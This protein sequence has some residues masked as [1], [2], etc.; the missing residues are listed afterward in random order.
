MSDES[1]HGIPATNLV[2]VK[3]LHLRSLEPFLSDDPVLVSFL[4]LQATLD[5]DKRSTKAA[6]NL[7]T[8]VGYLNHR[9]SSPPRYSLTSLTTRLLTPRECSPVSRSDGLLVMR[10]LLSVVG[11]RAEDTDH[12]RISAV[13]AF[14]MIMDAT[15]ESLPW[16]Q[17]QVTVSVTDGDMVGIGLRRI[18]KAIRFVHKCLRVDFI[19][20]SA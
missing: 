17:A 2:M 19:L 6:I 13:T 16:V 4:D 10:K 7:L 3:G 5:L 11:R 1:T 15:V 12:C 8:R 20:E 18:E 14:G 9:P